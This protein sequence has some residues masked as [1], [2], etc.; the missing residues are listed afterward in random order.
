M[1]RDGYGPMQ[2]TAG[3][4]TGQQRVLYKLRQ[5]IGTCNT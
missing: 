4:L 3:K 2:I 5:G 1:G